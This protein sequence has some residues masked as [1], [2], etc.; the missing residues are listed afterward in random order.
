MEISLEM[1]FQMLSPSV[2]P[3]RVIFSELK[4][5]ASDNLFLEDLHNTRTLQSNYYITDNEQATDFFF[6][7]ESQLQVRLGKVHGLKTA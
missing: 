1:T 7:R 3:P 6:S 2:Q 4:V 5:E